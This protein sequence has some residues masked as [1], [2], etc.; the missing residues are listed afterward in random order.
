MLGQ[1][2]YRKQ[3]NGANRRKR[4]KNNLY[5]LCVLGSFGYLLRRAGGAGKG[6]V[7]LYG[8]VNALRRCNHPSRIYIQQIYGRTGHVLGIPHSRNNHGSDIIFHLPPLLC[9]LL[10]RVKNKTAI[11]LIQ[12][13]RNTPR[14]SF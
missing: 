1:P 14:C 13:K 7:V 8:F 9:P 6:Y 4:L 12:S 2:H 3:R 5:R 10:R 11:S